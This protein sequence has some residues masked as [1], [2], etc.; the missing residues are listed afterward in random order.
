M[1]RC[2]KDIFVI[3]PQAKA[4][5]PIEFLPRN[6]VIQLEVVEGLLTKSLK[7]IIFHIH[8]FNDHGYFF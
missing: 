8:P 7:G 6:V 2:K 1:Q 3:L 5:W 4:S